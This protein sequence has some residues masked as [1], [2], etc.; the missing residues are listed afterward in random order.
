MTRNKPAVYYK[1]KKVDVLCYFQKKVKFKINTLLEIKE[2][3]MR[4]YNKYI[5]NWPI[6]YPLIY[7]QKFSK[8]TITVRYLNRL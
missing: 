4:S 2:F 7:K 8:F 6:K 1:K 3:Y 5:L